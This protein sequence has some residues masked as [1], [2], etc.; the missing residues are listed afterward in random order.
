MSVLVK[1]LQAYNGDSI[2]VSFNSE[3]GV[4]NILI[5]GGTGT[6][7]SKNGRP[8]D[9]KKEIRRIAAEGQSIDLLIITHIDD[10]HIGGILRM[11]SNKQFD[12]SLIK[13]VWFNS[14]RLI[15][16]MFE[17]EGEPLDRD[18]PLNRYSKLD[19]S[20]RQ[21]ATLEEY[22]KKGNS[23]VEE[24]IK[25]GKE[26]TLEGCKI[27]VLSPNEK[28]LKKLNN[29]WQTERPLSLEASPKQTD[30]HISIEDLIKSEDNFIE[31]NSIPNGSSIAILLTYNDCKILLLGDA[32]PN[33]ITT[34]L[35]EQG[36]TSANPLRLDLLKLS[37]H[38][39][40]KNTNDELLNLVDCDTFVTLT[41]GLKH[42][43]PDKVTFARIIKN[44]PGC[45]LL[46]NYNLPRIVFTK[47]E[48]NEMR[49]EATFL[50]RQ[51]LK[52]T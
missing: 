8:G 21:G 11:Y 18:I 30:Y 23:W 34:Y 24:I 20:V 15:S 40:K 28:G 5:D 3:K 7:Y 6:T 9:L 41:N 4:K 38:A 43:L 49:F 14:G 19:T 17:D 10:D 52:L 44:K 37:H 42:G 32:H 45:K 33:V 48:L 12:N 50:N 29:R 47:K 22:L 46:F 16:N 13:K 35:K 26:Y 2:L 25:Q 39:S 27:T 51:E 36:F 31:D 1:F